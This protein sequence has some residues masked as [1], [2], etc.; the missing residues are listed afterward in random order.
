[1]FF[2]VYG[3]GI[4]VKLN[5]LPRTFHNLCMFCALCH[6][7]EALATKNKE[8]THAQHEL[9]L[10]AQRD[11]AL[12]E[13][14]SAWATAPRDPTQAVAPKPEPLPAPPVAAAVPDAAPKPG[15]ANP[16]PDP[17]A[18]PAAAPAKKK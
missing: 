1:L 2:G 13:A 9:F 15:T 3:R 11:L 10:C 6:Q 14:F 5:R 17:Q 8:L 7:D 12:Q 18:K 4:Y 16:V